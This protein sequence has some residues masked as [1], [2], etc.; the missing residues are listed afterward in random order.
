MLKEL[1]LPEIHELIEQREWTLL[2]EVLSSWSPMEI[3]DLMLNVLKERVL[4]Y[5]ALPRDLAHEV[6]AYLEP[7][8]QINLI[9]ELTDSETREL[10]AALP[11]DDRTALLSELPADVT[12]RLLAL[13][14]P[15]DLREA[16]W[17][18]GYPEESVGRLM[19]PNF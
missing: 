10:L 5:R 8:Q 1:L 2:R 14:G 9:R 12:N 17:L 11:P 13:L 15:E 16:R 3:A 6:F 18:L 19:T 4:L 7:D